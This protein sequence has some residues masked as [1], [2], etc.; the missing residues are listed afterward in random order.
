MATEP[1]NEIDRAAIAEQAQRVAE[2]AALRKVRNTLDRLDATER[3]ERRAL[4]K[5]VLLCLVLALIG[6]WV[7][8]SLIYADKGM[9]KSPPMQL[10]SR[11]QGKS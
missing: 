10:P 4:R 6:G 2:Q 1:E 7:I 11:V 8:W 3:S 5:I 9:P